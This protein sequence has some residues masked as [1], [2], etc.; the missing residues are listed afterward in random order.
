MAI[1][2]QWIA[3]ARQ[4]PCPGPTSLCSSTRHGYHVPVWVR[5]QVTERRAEF[6]DEMESAL[7]RV[8]RAEES[9]RS[10]HEVATSRLQLRQSLFKVPDPH[11]NA[12]SGIEQ[13]QPLGAL[14]LLSFALW[15]H[16]K[17]GP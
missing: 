11:C 5:L 12:A 9:L 1:T 10:A 6:N 17:A 13:S 15:V 7:R 8:T 2:S 14:G 4:F 3:R 16:Y